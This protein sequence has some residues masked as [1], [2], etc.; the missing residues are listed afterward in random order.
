[1]NTFN[2]NGFRSIDLKLKSNEIKRMLKHWRHFANSIDDYPEG[3]SGKGIVTCAGGYGYFT[4]CWMLIKSLRDVGCNLEIEVW[5]LGNELSTDVRKQLENLGVNCRD[6]LDYGISEVASGYILKPMAIKNSKFKE[7]LFLDADNFSVKNPEALFTLEGYLENG[8]LFWPDYWTTPSENPI[9]DIID[10]PFVKEK[11]QESGQILIN[12][13]LCWRELNLCLYFNDH[14]HMYYH[15]IH[16]DKDT[17]RFAWKA[18]NSGY[19]MI[20][21]E[22]ASCGYF[23]RLSNF[24]GTT[25]VQHCPQG[26]IYFLHR[27]LLKWDVTLPSEKVWKAVKRFKENDHEGEYEMSVSEV[28]HIFM[29]LHGDTE[30]ISFADL[31]DDLEDNCLDHLKKLRCEAFF[32]DYGLYSWIA[33]MRYSDKAIFEI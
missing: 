3:Y 18:L 26:E 4:C 10:A 16:G 1:M 22:P 14:A 29:D 6:F 24:K 19:Y 23:D 12:K 21:H 7:V 25:I 31:F 15:L 28:G 11:E 30:T 13:E 9:W 27:N 17:F 2:R 20:A 33:K 32:K 5:H 8:A